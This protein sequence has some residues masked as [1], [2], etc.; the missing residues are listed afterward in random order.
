MRGSA[1]GEAKAAIVIHLIICIL[2]KRYTIMYDNRSEYKREV[3]V[4]MTLFE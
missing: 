3:A 2:M 4:R 1:G